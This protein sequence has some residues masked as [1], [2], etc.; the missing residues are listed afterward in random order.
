M[1][2][3]K[4]NTRPEILAWLEKM[5]VENFTINQDLTV[6]VDGSV[7]LINKGLSFIPIQFGVVKGIFQCSNNKLTSLLGT[8]HLIKGIFKCSGNQLTNLVGGPEIAD[9]AYECHNNH[10]TTLL[11][12]PKETKYF[13]C[14]N[15]NLTNI[16]NG[17]LV[18]Q[19]FICH[20]NPI[21]ITKP[22]QTKIKRSFTHHNDDKTCI[23]L[24]KAYYQDH[25]IHETKKIHYEIFLQSDEFERKLAQFLIQYE[26]EHLENEI[27]LSNQPKKIKL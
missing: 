19:N 11:G 6:D 26:K 23:D 24:F 2:T 10:L 16:E 12:S 20:N 14:S 22:I 18:V 9:F 7:D 27:S 25:F 1:N 5:G 8:P 17:P 21:Q 3:K 13:D 15:N 4:L